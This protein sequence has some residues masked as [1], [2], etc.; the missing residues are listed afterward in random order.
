MSTPRWMSEWYDAQPRA[1]VCR[2][3]GKEGDRAYV[4]PQAPRR[5][6]DLAGYVPYALCCDCIMAINRRMDRDRKAQL[7]A[8]PR[9]DVS[10]C[11]RRGRWRIGNGPGAKVLVCGSHYTKAKRAWNRRFAGAMCWLPAPTMSRDAMLELAES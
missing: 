11:K 5:K 8:M 3:C 1:Q 2:D 7:D 6:A 10:G 9:C 4:Q